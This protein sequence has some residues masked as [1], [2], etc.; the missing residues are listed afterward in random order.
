MS[1]SYISSIV[2]IITAGV[3]FANI[4]WSSPEAITPIVT[5]IVTLVAGA[6][7]A[8]RKYQTGTVT[9]AGKRK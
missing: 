4:D 9:L 3:Q 5:A 6:I 1:P 8:Y 2:V 7:I